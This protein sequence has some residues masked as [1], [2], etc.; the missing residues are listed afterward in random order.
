MRQTVL[1][2]QLKKT[3][4]R[5]KLVKATARLLVRKRDEG[6]PVDSL[7]SCNFG[8]PFGKEEAKPRKTRNTR[9]SITGSFRVVRIFL[10]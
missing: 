2:P 4:D 7:P 8:I 1:T 5:V 9:K 6:L 3:K 10:G